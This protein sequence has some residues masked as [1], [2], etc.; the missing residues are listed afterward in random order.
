MFPIRLWPF[1]SLDLLALIACL[2][3][4]HSAAQGQAPLAPSAW[5]GS[6]GIGYST[7]LLSS[8][9]AE[10]DAFGPDDPHYLF[11]V[12]RPRTGRAL[13]DSGVVGTS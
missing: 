13:F 7:N 11:V 4:S 1:R 12:D 5:G 6:A 8:S 3:V 2:C 9:R 10:M